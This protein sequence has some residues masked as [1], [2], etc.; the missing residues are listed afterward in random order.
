MSNK[1]TNKVSVDGENILV[2]I[3]S[4]NTELRGQVDAL[5]IGGID[6]ASTV[7]LKGTD[8]DAVEK[9]IKLY[10]EKVKGE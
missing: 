1:A 9:A 4:R 8:I 2:V 7:L 6:Y 3:S 5:T 10:K